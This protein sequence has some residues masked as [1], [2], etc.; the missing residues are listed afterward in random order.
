MVKLIV[1]L[2]LTVDWITISDLVSFPFIQHANDGD[3]DDYG[4]ANLCYLWFLIIF[5]IFFPVTFMYYPMDKWCNSEMV[6][7]GGA[8]MV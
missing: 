3:P 2:Y 1:Y 7:D 5:I 4:V 8:M 6:T